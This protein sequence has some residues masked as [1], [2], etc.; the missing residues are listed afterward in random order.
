MPKKAQK[1]EAGGMPEDFSLLLFGPPKIGKTT[2]GASFP[3]S[4]L[5]E[6]EPK[7]AR[8]ING[9]VINVGSLDELRDVFKLLKNDPGYCKT[10]VIDTLDRIAQ[11][12]E[13]EVCEDMGLSNIMESKKGAKHGAQW[14]EY[15]HRI[16]TQLEGWK[17]L[18]KRVVFLAH[19]KKAEID[20][21]GLVI[22]PKTINLYGQAA[23]RVLSIVENVGHMYA[24]KGDMNKPERVLSFA[25]G[26]VVEAGARHPL[27][28][29]R[30]VV[31]GKENP[32]AA[33]EGLFKP[34][35]AAK[36]NGAKKLPKK[37]RK[38]AVG[39]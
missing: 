37:K 10:V 24:R 16:L 13:A 27:L 8:Y 34:T 39:V 22:S 3:D 33:L 4:L 14:A 17:L 30:V 26:T 25:P 7:G 35:A 5:I 19:T 15:S 23:N 32:Y 9:R 11:W 31:I 2:F 28:A 1:G 36:T 12:V 29:D 6:C 38:E 21:E 18:G 20:G